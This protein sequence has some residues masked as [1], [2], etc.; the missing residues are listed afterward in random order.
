LW[1]NEAGGKAARLDGS[2]YR[3]D[4]A[5]KPGLVGASSPAIWDQ[6]VARVLA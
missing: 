5:D 1:L 6:F 3:V 2:E 4:E